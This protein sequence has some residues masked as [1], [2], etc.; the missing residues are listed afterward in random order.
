[1]SNDK[2]NIE[3]VVNMAK[4]FFLKEYGFSCDGE[5]NI[6]YEIYTDY[7]DEL[8]KG[9]IEKAFDYA[10]GNIEA[11]TDYLN[12]E[13]FQSYV[14]VFCDKEYDLA[15]E[16]LNYMRKTLDEIVLY[17][18]ELDNLL[19]GAEIREVLIDYGVVTVGVDY[20]D[21]YARSN[22]DLVVMMEGYESK[23]HEF[24]LNNFNGDIQEWIE[25]TQDWIDRGEIKENDISLITLLKSQGYT[26][27]QFKDEVGK[28]YS[29]PTYRPSSKFIRSLINECY[30]TT[31]PCNALAFLVQINLSD[32][33]KGNSVKIIEK[34]CCGGYVDFVYGG[35]SVLGIDLEVD[36][37]L[38]SIQHETFI[39]GQKYGYSIKSI[40]GDFVR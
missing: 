27:N 1:M 28:C 2:E 6:N 3:L 14:D 26:W 31:S 30:N 17:R 15:C 5:G 20:D 40:Y 23:N 19:D 39:D 11:L 10:N 8:S 22:I 32:Y 33:L 29:Q 4:E 37:P 9:T 13:I 35:G 18:L 38:H 16:V 36:I 34:N 21:I 12:E 25:E 7:N 24:T